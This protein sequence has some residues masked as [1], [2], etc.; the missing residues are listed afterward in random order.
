MTRATKSQHFSAF[1]NFMNVHK[2]NF[3]LMWAI[4]KLLGQIKPKFIIRS[5]FLAA[6]FFILI[7]ILLSYNNRCWHA[8]AILVKFWHN[9]GFFATS[10]VIMLFCHYWTI[11][12]TLGVVILRGGAR[13]VPGGA[14]APPKFC[15]APPKF[16]AWRHATALKSYTDHWQ[17]PLLQNWPLQCPPPNETVCLR[18]WWYLMLKYNNIQPSQWFQEI[19][20]HWM[21]LLCVWI[22]FRLW[23]CTSGFVGSFTL[24][25]FLS[26]QQK[27][28][29]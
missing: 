1:S 17:L 24:L 19:F 8:F 9:I 18:P 7:D 13:G 20:W 2:P 28:N 12:S 3:S 10:D 21:F 14:T 11:E 25:I 29:S 5:K 23:F 15:L 27:N 16:S 22:D 26:F 6:Q 4:P